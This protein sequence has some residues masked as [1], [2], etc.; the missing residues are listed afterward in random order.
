MSILVSFISGFLCKL[1]V[2]VLNDRL[3]RLILWVLWL[4][5][6]L[7]VFCIWLELLC[8]NELSIGCLMFSWLV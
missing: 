5:M 8:I 4:V 2:L 3:S 7:K 6:R 1:L